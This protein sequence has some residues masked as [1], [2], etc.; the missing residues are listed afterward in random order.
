MLRPLPIS[1]GSAYLGTMGAA[2][3][4]PPQTLKHKRWPRGR[5]AVPNDRENACAVG[6]YDTAQRESTLDQ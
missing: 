1:G 6:C 5:I 3:P 2:T 4:N